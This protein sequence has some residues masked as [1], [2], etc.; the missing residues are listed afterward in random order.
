MLRADVDNMGTAFVSGF[1]RDEAAAADKYKYLT[2]SRT[3]TLSR[4][5]SIFFKY[6]LNDL[7]ADGGEFDLLAPP[8]Q[9]NLVVVYSGGDD[10][11]LVG[12]WND[13]LSAA[14]DIRR[15]FA[16]Y[17]CNTL[18]M[19]AGFAMFEPGYPIARMAEETAWLE[20]R[21]KGHRYQGKM[22]NSISLFGLEMDGGQLQARHTYDWDTF[23]N[24]VLG[25]KY[26]VL[27]SIFSGGEDYGSSFL[28]NILDLLRQ[29]EKDRINIA[30]LAY[31]LARREPDRK[32]SG[33]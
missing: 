33:N 21:A 16:R 14:I 30:R 15:S 25:E 17:T 11:F 13:V 12:A 23:E 7:L 10:L 24:Q 22:K 18:T 32:A 28:Y 26:A 6:Y 3:A 5:L 1:V 29:A 8:K 4:S 19:S 31:L 27:D 20:E 9:R 2:I